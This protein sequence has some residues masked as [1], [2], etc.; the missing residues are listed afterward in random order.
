MKYYCITLRIT[1]PDLVSYEIKFNDAIIYKN[2][3]HLI[4][5]HECSK[6]ILAHYPLTW[7]LEVIKMDIKENN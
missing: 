7:V 5:K 2:D 6:Y 4:V 3:T 1:K